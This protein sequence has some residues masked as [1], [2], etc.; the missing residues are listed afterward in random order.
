MVRACWLLSSSVPAWGR[1]EPL[2]P[3]STL[4]WSYGPW[5]P[6][7]LGCKRRVFGGWV[8]FSRVLLPV[9]PPL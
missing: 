4:P 1:Q 9:P 3:P 5:G 8:Q 7:A 6:M 2:P